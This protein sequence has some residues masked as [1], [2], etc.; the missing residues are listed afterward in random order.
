MRIFAMG[1]ALVDQEFQ[2]TDALLDSL[3]LT[4]GHMA[5]IDEAEL[6]ANCARLGTPLRRC[7]GG[8]AANSAAAYV[9][10]GGE[11]YLCG[12]V[13]K[14]D[15]G[16]WF[17]GDL[18][19]YGVQCRPFSACSDFSAVTTGTTGT[20]GQCLVLISE[21][22]ERTML[23]FLGVSAELRESDLDQSAL[24]C[25][26]LV[27]VEGYMASGD[28]STETCAKALE[29]A[30]SR[31]MATA[32]SLSDASMIEYCRP[33]LERLLSHPVTHLFCNLEEA[34]LMTGSDR[35]DEACA[36]LSK[37]AEY[38]HV[39]LGAKGSLCRTGSQEARADVQATSGVVD[40]TGAGDMYA[41]AVLHAYAAKA[42]AAEMA[43]FGNFAAARIVS[44]Y[45][46]RLARREDYAQLLAEFHNSH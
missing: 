21:D 18:Q 31:G 45:G 7:G 27:Y 23:T 35:L 41:G 36:A 28:V 12:R 30:R 43:A 15:V 6:R 34:M 5:L 44:H 42:D 40:T 46:A 10:F 26:D 39:T 11:A 16:H 13:A 4:K 29:L 37:Q 20:S 38:L 25:S 14:D 1:N 33:N 24:E 8:S 17:L 9:G 19:G 22:A 2:V 32:L 3:R